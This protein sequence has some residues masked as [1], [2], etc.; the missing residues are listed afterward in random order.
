LILTII[1]LWIFRIASRIAPPFISVNEIIMGILPKISAEITKGT[2][3]SQTSAERHHFHSK[4]VPL[5]PK[6]APQIG[7]LNENT[8]PIR[9]II[10]RF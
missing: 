7:T 1:T 5:T 2:P 3:Y 9:L 10:N 6:Y 4:V 8:H